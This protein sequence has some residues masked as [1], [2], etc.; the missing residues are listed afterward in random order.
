MLRSI[1]RL[2]MFSSSTLLLGTFAFLIPSTASAQ[3]KFAVPYEY[4]ASCQSCHGVSAT[5]DGAMATEL[6]KKPS[7]LT[8]LAKRNGG[9]FPFLK[10]FHT[11]DGR[12]EIPAHGTSDMPVWGARYK[13]DIGEKYGP[14]GGEA[15]IRARILELVYYIQ[16][17][18]K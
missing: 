3:V 13:K 5:G 7:D 4:Q 6:K 1:W 17:I 9:N 14:Y 18:Q 15:A 12:Q 2:T 11:I 10:V 8:T 16:S